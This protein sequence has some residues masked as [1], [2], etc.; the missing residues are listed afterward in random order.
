MFRGWTDRGWCGNSAPAG[1]RGVVVGRLLPV[2]AWTE[3]VLDTGHCRYAWFGEAKPF[4]SSRA[5][6]FNDGDALRGRRL[7]GGHGARRL[8][9]GLKAT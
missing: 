6:T 4:G 8:K 2:Q 1:M 3:P 7:G 9:G 5:G